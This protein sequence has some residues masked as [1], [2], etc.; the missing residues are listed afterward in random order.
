[1]LLR[2]YGSASQLADY[3]DG[4]PTCAFGR[5]SFHNSPT[6]SATNRKALSAPPRGES[7]AAR[8]AN[9]FDP[10]IRLLSRRKRNTLLRPGSTRFRIDALK[11]VPWSRYL[12]DRPRQR[13]PPALDRSL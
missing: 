12:S 6:H 13:R 5:F 2:W 4:R 1:M 8:H 3:P 11:A 9:T 10:G 7:W